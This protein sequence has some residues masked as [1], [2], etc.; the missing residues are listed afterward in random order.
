MTQ[1]IVLR[2]REKNVLVQYI[3]CMV[4]TLCSI[5]L[6]NVESHKFDLFYFSNTISYKH[7]L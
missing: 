5:T 1:V 6:R 3:V 2:R 7:L 4:I